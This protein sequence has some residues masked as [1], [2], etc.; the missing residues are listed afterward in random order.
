VTYLHGRS[1]EDLEQYTDGLLNRT[2]GGDIVQAQWRGN[3][4]DGTYSA[5]GGRDSS[6]LVFSVPDRPLAG[7]I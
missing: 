5:V 6:V 2:G 3:A 1:A 4:L 7:F